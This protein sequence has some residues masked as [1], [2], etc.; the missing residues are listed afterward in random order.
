MKAF[1]LALA[2]AFVVATN[3]VPMTVHGQTAVPGPAAKGTWT[4]GPRRR[5]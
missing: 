3:A 5:R 1:Q 2:C 4:H